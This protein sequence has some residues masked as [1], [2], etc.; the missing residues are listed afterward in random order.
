MCKRKVFIQDPDARKK[1][2]CVLTHLRVVDVLSAEEIANVQAYP[3]VQDKV[4]LLVDTVARK[5]NKASS[6]L[7]NAWA[8]VSASSFRTTSRLTH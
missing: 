1:L 3:V 6:E 7:L 5:G 2:P 8:K 4:R